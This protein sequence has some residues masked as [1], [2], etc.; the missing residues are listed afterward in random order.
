MPTRPTP[1]FAR[2]LGWPLPGEAIG[3]IG[4][5]L[6][7]SSLARKWF[8]GGLDKWKAISSYG[9][10]LKGRCRGRA[11]RPEGR[12]HHVCGPLTLQGQGRA[13]PQ[14][15]PYTNQFNFPVPGWEYR[16][17]TGPVPLH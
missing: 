11:D 12:V 10:V 15:G 8:Q 3:A 5:L 1:R 4:Y 2:E 14:H 7:L 13:G 16:V 6:F 17:A 9:D